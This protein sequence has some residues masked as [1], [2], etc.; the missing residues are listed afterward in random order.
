MLLEK[1]LEVNGKIT[2]RLLEQNAP[3]KRKELIHDI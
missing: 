1:A 3:A 2:G